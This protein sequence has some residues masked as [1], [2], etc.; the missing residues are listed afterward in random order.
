MW[1]LIPPLN[2]GVSEFSP[3]DVGF[4]N[5]PLIRRRLGG[6]SLTY[7]LGLVFPSQNRGQR[8]KCLFEGRLEEKRVSSNESSVDPTSSLSPT[9]A[10]LDH[11][12]DAMG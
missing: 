8:I 10:H 6:S 2:V 11:D 12:L 4:T 9:V 3:L 7:D 5:M 1:N